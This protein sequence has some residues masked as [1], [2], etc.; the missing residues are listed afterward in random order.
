MKARIIGELFG[1]GWSKVNRFRTERTP[2]VGIAAARSTRGR[3]LLRAA[4][5]VP[6]AVFKP[7]KKGGCH[8]TAQLRN[9]LAYVCQKSTIIVD[10]TGRFD[11][12]EVLT[13]KEIKRVAETWADSWTHK[14]RLG[15][16]THMIMAFPRG[17]TIQQVAAITS[18][19]CAEKFQNATEHYDYLIA[20]HDDRD[21]K[22]AHIILNRYSNV[23]KGELFYLSKDHHYN[24][25]A[26]REA[27]VEVG[28]RHGVTVEATRRIE[29]GVMT[30]RAPIEEIY[31]AKAE[32][33]APV[34]AMRTGTALAI[35]QRAAAASASTIADMAEAA[36]QFKRSAEADR[37]IRAASV[38]RAGQALTHHN[39]VATVQEV[40]MSERTLDSTIDR[41]NAAYD[42]AVDRI[43]RIDAKDR[44]GAQKEL[45]EILARIERLRPLGDRSHELNERASDAGVYSATANRPDT[46]EILER[47]E[48]QARVQHAL[49]G[50]GIRAEEVTERVAVRAETVAVEREW[51]TEDL[52]AIAAEKGLDLE[53]DE[54]LNEAL[55]ELSAVQD[56]L[57]TVLREENVRLSDDEIERSRPDVFSEGERQ[58]FRQLVSQFRRTDFSYPYS[59][60]PA[61]RRAGRQEVE[62][63]RVAFEGFA[64][65]SRQHAELATMAWEQATDF[66]RPPRHAVPEN[67]RTLHAGDMELAMRD[68]SERLG[69]ITEEARTL[70]RYRAEMPDDEL[71]EVIQGEINQLRARGASRAQ[72]SERSI[73]IEDRIRQTYAERRHLEQTA[74]ELVAVMRQASSGKVEPMSEADQ[75]RLVDQIDARLTPD[76][77]K[78]LQ[79]G[80]V[81][82]LDRITDNRL[83]QLELAKSYLQANKAT[84][85]GPAMDRVLGEIVRHRHGVEQ[86]RDT[87]SN[88]KH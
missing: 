81:E 10:P 7:V 63:A 55:R 62:D 16:T 25:D 2:H 79:S 36:T 13:D 72:I 53:R 59:D 49:Q 31:R 6:P 44:P 42:T 21:H 43:S 82:V 8:T 45:A 85:S 24:Y 30:W 41:F 29:R 17:T 32:G 69:P 77:I 84:A 46:R 70:A 22:H 48:V 33:R 12:R 80:N 35:G 64:Q 15:H 61:M 23:A 65:R 40:V 37:L 28:E 86:L 1:E 54:D 68:P 38:L 66:M 5:G 71:R 20:V 27:M 83:H 56:R 57:A 4:K 3:M 14:P 78:E 74:P 50:T 18:E 47:A 60:D 75:Q 52:R 51:E 26:F 11:G 34:E 39:P 73:E 9:Q 76:D 88:L 58:D 19:I 67:A 87:D